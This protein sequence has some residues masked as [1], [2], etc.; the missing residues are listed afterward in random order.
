[1]QYLHTATRQARSVTVSDFGRVN[2]TASSVQFSCLIE[3]LSSKHTETLL[4]R[5]PG[6]RYRI[7]W[8]GSVGEMEDGDVITFSGKDYILQEVTPDTLRPR[9]PYYTAVMVEER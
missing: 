6:A 8:P 3:P 7:T 1:M 4:G 9:D 2:T 5:I